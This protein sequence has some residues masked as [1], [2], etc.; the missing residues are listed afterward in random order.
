[1]YS[2]TD[3]ATLKERIGAMRAELLLYVVDKRQSLHFRQLFE[4]ARLTGIAGPDVRLEHIAFGTVNGPDGRPF[5]TRAGGV[6]RL[7]DLMALA[8]DQAAR[9]LQQAHIAER[10]PAAE[11]Q[12]IARMVALA[13]IK[14]A[15]L[16][17]HRTSDY[18]FDLET[19][20]RFEG[21]TG[22]YLLYSAVRIKSLL[23][24]A[25]EAGLQP[26]AI[27]PP[28]RD[29]ERDL[30]LALAQLPRAVATAYDRRAPNDLCEFAYTLAQSFSRFYE[31][32]HILTEPDSALQA[33]WLALSTLSLRT[34]E[35]TL[36]LLGIELPERM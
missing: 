6:M 29:V 1:M 12:E 13:T 10:Y 9:R 20:S 17:N 16:S 11:R 33:S 19:V 31:H 25:A 7:Q 4:A 2:T 23:A 3:L 22:P 15:D 27:A 30:L 8:R 14:Y 28:S 24:K 34:L 35:R 21:R 26:G 18:V 32:C 36:D 5:K